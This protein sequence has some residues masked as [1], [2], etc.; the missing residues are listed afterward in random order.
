ME[1][2]N[3]EYVKPRLQTITV[4]YLLKLIDLLCFQKMGWYD[5]Y[6]IFDTQVIAAGKVEVWIYYLRINNASLPGVVILMEQFF[7]LESLQPL[8]ENQIFHP[9]SQNRLGLGQYLS[10]FLSIAFS[11]FLQWLYLSVEFSHRCPFGPIR[12]LFLKRCQSFYFSNNCL[13]HVHFVHELLPDDFVFEHHSLAIS[14]G[15]ELKEEF[16]QSLIILRAQDL[17]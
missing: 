11:H 8:L 6:I 14:D 16:F 13:V 1:K 10:T 3:H 2:L 12:E 5:G 9:N 7:V 15:H 4:E 17:L